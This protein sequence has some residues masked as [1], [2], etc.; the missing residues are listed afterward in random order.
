MLIL[1]GDSKKLMDC[2]AVVV[3][4][5][6]DY[7]D[8][9]RVFCYDVK[10]IISNGREELISKFDTEDKAREFVELLSLDLAANRRAKEYYHGPTV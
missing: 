1:S 10:G 7:A 9:E 6:M 8:R 3:K 5:R 2:M 4:K